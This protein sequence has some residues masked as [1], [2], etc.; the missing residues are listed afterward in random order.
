MVKQKPIR[1]LIERSSLGSPDARAARARVPVRTGR[2]IA[3]AATSGRYV[4]MAAAARHPR[5]AATSG[6]HGTGG[7]SSQ[8]SS[9]HGHL[10]QGAGRSNP[11]SDLRTIAVADGELL[12]V[13]LVLDAQQRV[14]VLRL[15]WLG[16]SD[17][18]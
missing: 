13:W 4:T 16:G 1:T 10:H 11:G 7:N 15:V 8:G 18:R 17:D 3:R 9:R 2:A 6:R 14:E 12:V 5:P